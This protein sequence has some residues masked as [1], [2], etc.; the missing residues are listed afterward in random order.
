M[1]GHCTCVEV[2]G[3]LLG[4]SSLLVCNMWGQAQVVRLLHASLYLMGYIGP[5]PHI[6]TNTFTSRQTLS[7][8]AA[9]EVFNLLV[10]ASQVARR[11]PDPKTILGGGGE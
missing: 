8:L 6:N 11:M 10:L 3:Q 5:H 9:P 7:Y 4:V 2:R 1:C